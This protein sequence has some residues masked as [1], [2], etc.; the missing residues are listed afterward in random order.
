M[1]ASGACRIG[2]PTNV[3]LRSS[4]TKSLQVRRRMSVEVRVRHGPRLRLVV[5]DGA[6]AAAS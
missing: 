3:S 5:G 1:L 2:Y 6:E 4:D